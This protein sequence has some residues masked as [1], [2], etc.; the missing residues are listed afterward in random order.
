M[1]WVKRFGHIPCPEFTDDAY[2]RLTEAR[3]MK[4]PC[5]I[6]VIQDGRWQRLRAYDFTVKKGT[7]SEWNDNPA[8]SPRQGELNPDH[9]DVFD[10]DIDF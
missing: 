9:F 1:W 5:K 6:E 10:T 7:P 8:G 4:E 3:G 2:Q